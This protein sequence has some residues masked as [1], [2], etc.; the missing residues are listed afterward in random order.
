MAMSVLTPIERAQYNDRKRFERIKTLPTREIR[1][2]DVE[3][4][5]DMQETTARNVLLR[6]EKMGLL[7]K[8]RRGAWERVAKSEQGVN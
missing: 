6:L 3:Q 7:R 4:M 1:C 8:V 5:F 2:R